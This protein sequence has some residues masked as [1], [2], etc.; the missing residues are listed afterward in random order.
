M[1]KEVEAELSSVTPAKETVLT[2]GVFDGVHLGHQHLMKQLREEAG[3]RG[4]LSGVITFRSHPRT[5]LSPGERVSCL[6]S[7]E[8]R[9]E[10][11]RAQGVDIVLAISFTREL[12]QITAREFVELLMKHLRM[13]ALVVGPD[14][15]LGRNRE[16]N[17]SFLKKLGREMGFGVTTVD[18]LKQGNRV[19]SSTAIRQALAEGDVATAAR[20]LGRPFSLKG[21]VVRGTERGRRLGF[22]TANLAFQSDL[23]IPADGVYATRA[24]VSEIP[25]QAVTNIGTRPTFGE[26]TRTIEVYILD[27]ESNLY[28]Q[29]IQIELIKRLRG[30][31]R[32]ASEEELK[33]QIKRD[34]EQARAILG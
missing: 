17:I 2:I 8:E 13:K 12:S 1:Q 29:E 22:P 4:C 26:E 24:Y 14:F 16:G 10:R 30:E 7:L 5:V 33:T 23:A 34:V 27:F 32:F 25:R 18:P 21:P 6:S 28:G 3:K 20:L 19:V 31:V 15:A 9:I 11:I